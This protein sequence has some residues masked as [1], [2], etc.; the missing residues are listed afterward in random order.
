MSEAP[1]SSEAPSSSEA[2]LSIEGH[3]IVFATEWGEARAVVGLY[4]QVHPGQTLGLVGES[5][6]G[7]SVTALSILRLLPTPPAR[8]AGGTLRWQGRDLMALSHAELR[9]VRGREIGMIFQEPMTSL[10]PVYSCGEQID[11]VLRLHEGLSRKEA[12]ART[13]ELLRQVGIPDPEHRAREYPHQLSGGLRQRIMIAMAIACGPEL[14]IADEPTTALDVTIQG[15]ILDLLDSL[16][17]RSGMGILHITHD[18]GVIASSAQ[19]LAVMYAGR[20]VER[21]PAR[22]LLGRPAHPYTLGLLASRPESSQAG[23]PLSVISGS[24]PDPVEPIAGCRFSPRCPFANER[25]RAEEPDLEAWDDARSVA[26]FERD[27]V[28][29]RGVWP[30]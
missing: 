16:Q 18:L 14:L 2:L 7:K 6:C 25:C 26:C 5:G 1:L 28:L 9:R 19:E 10:N 11:E 8:I 17:E 4:R 15:Q 29:E 13:V 27:E 12:R 24:V 21:G 22:E 30:G 23:R 20:V 3:R